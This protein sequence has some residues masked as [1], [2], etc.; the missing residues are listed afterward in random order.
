MFCWK[1]LLICL[2]SEGGGNS[3]LEESDE[4]PISL[5]SLQLCWNCVREELFSVAVNLE[6]P[7]RSTFYVCSF[8][9]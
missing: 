6:T 5:T 1:I 2:L 8:R 7:K 9:L 3:G 4:N